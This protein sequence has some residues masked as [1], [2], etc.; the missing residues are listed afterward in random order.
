MKLRLLLFPFLLLGLLFASLSV[1]SLWTW[2]SFN[3]DHAIH[4]LMMEDFQIPKDWYYW[5]QNRL[6]SFLPFVG[7]LLVHLGFSSLV[8]A[9]LVQ[10]LMLSAI[11][12]LV[13]RLYGPSVW[14]IAALC[15]LLF[16]IFPFWMQISLG[17]PYVAQLLF[18]L[19]FLLLVKSYKQL[20]FSGW[21]SLGILAFLGIWS[22]EL[23]LGFLLA[24]LIVYLPIS[25]Q[26]K[27][28]D[29][30]PLGL[31]LM[32]GA[33]FLYQA[34]AHAVDVKQ[35]AQRFANGSQIQESFQTQWASILSLLNCTS[36][37]WFNTVLLY[38]ELVLSFVLAWL[39]RRKRTAFLKQTKVLLLAGLISFIMIHISHWNH[40]MG[41][42]MRYFTSAYI[43]FIL[44][45]ISGYKDLKLEMGF[46]LMLAGPLSLSILSASLI[47]QAQF[48]TGAE[49]RIERLEAEDLIVQQLPENGEQL[50]VLGSYW[51]SYLLDAL[52]DRVVAMPRQGAYIRDYRMQEQ[53]AAAQKFLVIGNDWLDAFPERIEQ[54]GV[55]LQKQGEPATID[56]EIRYA[57]YYK[58]D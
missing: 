5:G 31:G 23:H 35:Y 10:A 3:S 56:G 57:I 32:I 6:G 18:G 52:S 30:V 49:G 12:F 41:L 26:L 28:Q 51:N 34:K 47:Y 2:P 39:G 38:I 21:L 58:L 40:L 44:G 29:W 50:S 20:R 7:S 17:H 27:W 19:L 24:A 25:R 42:P 43:W 13:Y 48:D 11:A 55:S 15:A 1:F 54:H 22:T 36:P 14:S 46:S 45:L 37:K 16:P 33:L 53:W 4:V 9:G 8:A